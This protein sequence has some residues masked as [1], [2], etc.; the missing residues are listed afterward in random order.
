MIVSIFALMLLLGL[1]AT[2]VGVVVIAIVTKKLWLIP[3]GAAIVLFV[4]IGL[5]IV[6]SLFVGFTQRS[7]QSATIEMLPQSPSMVSSVSFPTETIVSS[8]PNFVASG[9]PI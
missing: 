5:G 7:V 2:A 6:A 1:C 3:A 4:L 9:P 8:P